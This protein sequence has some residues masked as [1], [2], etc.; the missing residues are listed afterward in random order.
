[1]SFNSIFRKYCVCGAKYIC[2][3]DVACGLGLS[4]FVLNPCTCWRE[5]QKQ[6]RKQTTTTKRVSTF[7]CSSIEGEEGT[8]CVV[9]ADWESGGLEKWGEGC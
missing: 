4:A 6:K 5:L 9:V 3:L 7:V 2:E 8:V 1:M